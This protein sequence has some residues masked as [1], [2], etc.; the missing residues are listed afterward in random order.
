MYKVENSWGL[1]HEKTFRV[2][3]YLD[4]KKWGE[5]EGS[6]KQRAEQQAAHYAL[7]KLKKV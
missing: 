5:G 1:D 3:V 4:D 2:A 7:E 6:S